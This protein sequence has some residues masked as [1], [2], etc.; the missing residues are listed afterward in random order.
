MK[1][2]FSMVLGIT[3]LFTLVSC[4]K[5][6]SRDSNSQEQK[7]EEKGSSSEDEGEKIHMLTGKKV[8]FIGNSY[9]YWG[10]TVLNKDKALK[11]LKY[12][13]NDEGFFYQLCKAMGAEVSVTNWTFGGHSVKELFNENC[14]YCNVDHKEYLT[15]RNYD[16]VIVSPGAESDFDNSM[17]KV[18]NFFLDENPNTEFVILG[19]QAAYGYSAYGDKV[20]YIKDLYQA[21]EDEGVRIADW[22]GMMDGILT[23]KYAVAGATQEYNKRTFIIPDNRHGTMLTGYIEAMFVYCV[24]TGESAVGLPYDFCGNTKIR[25]EFDMEKFK[26]EHFT[27]TES[28]NFIQVFQSPSDMRGLQMLIDRYMKEKP[29]R[30]DKE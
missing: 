1:R 11:E 19:N 24:I 26:A 16:Y 10:K 7:E 14:K 21:Y 6:D 15:D 22:G 18:I 29:Y 23:Q 4:T 20:C 9:V 28:T 12:R 27:G 5:N 3:L 17:S 8:I 30:T 25:T 2:F 13:Q